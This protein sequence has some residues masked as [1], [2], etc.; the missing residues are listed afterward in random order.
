MRKVEP[1]ERKS[2][3][4]PSWIRRNVIHAAPMWVQL[5]RTAVANV[6]TD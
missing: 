5:Y 3:A 2:K 6:R 1:R 4:V